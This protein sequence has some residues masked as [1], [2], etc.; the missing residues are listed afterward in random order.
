ML[1][2]KLKK[3]LQTLFFGEFFPGSFILLDGET[4]EVKGNW[5]KGGK[6]PALGYDFWYQP[7]HNVLLSTEWG[8]PR[9]L[10]QGFHPR[11]VEQGRWQIPEN[12]LSEQKF[13]KK[14]LF[15][16]RQKFQ[17]NQIFES[18]NTWKI[19]FLRVE[20]PQKFIF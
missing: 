1:S 4:F 5:E 7:R 11:D 9:V 16:L 6:T 17:K 8:V 3:Y 12:S 19:Q 2:L 18:K 14:S 20:I 13:L 10:A 15:F